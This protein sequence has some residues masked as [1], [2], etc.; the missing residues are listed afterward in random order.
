MGRSLLEVSPF[1]KTGGE[2]VSSISFSRVPGGLWAWSPHSSLLPGDTSTLPHCPPG[3]GPVAHS[4][5]LWAVG[6]GLPAGLCR[7][8]KT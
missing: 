8:E 4:Q 5:D 2:V 3:P 7:A 1:E 6:C